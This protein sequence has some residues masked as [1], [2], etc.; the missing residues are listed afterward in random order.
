M[1]LKKFKLFCEVRLA[2]LANIIGTGDVSDRMKEIKEK[3]FDIS[4]KLPTS[5]NLKNGSILKIKWNDN[6]T[7]NLPKRIKERTSFGDIDDFIE[8][9]KEKFIEIFP[10]KVG[11]D[12][13][14]TGRYSIYIKEYNISFIVYFDLNKNMRNY[15][16]NI[17]TVL[18]GRK[19]N[20][21]VKFIDI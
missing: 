4:Q 12:L 17:I 6:A 14:Q 1:I 5:I 8:Y 15:F 13:F 20:N 2:D 16:I 3:E 9:L 19:G 11:K 18:P 21:I 7:H 10:D